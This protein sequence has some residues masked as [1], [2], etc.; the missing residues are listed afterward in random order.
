MK[1]YKDIDSYIKDAPKETQKSLKEIYA[2]IKKLLPKNVEEAI[3]YGIPT[4]RLNGNLI[5]FGGFKTHISLFPGASGVAKFKNDL[6]KYNV[7]K[8]TIQF[9]LDKPIPKT[10]IKKIVMFRIKENLAK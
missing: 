5:H 10:L 8:G 1:T 9:P 2:F 4:F 7:S 6:K 3:R